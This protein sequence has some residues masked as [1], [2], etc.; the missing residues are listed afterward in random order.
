MN[1]LRFRYEPD[2]N[3]CGRLIVK[4][5]ANDYAGRGQSWFSPDDLRDFAK[6]TMSY[7]LSVES[8]PSLGAG[9]YDEQG[10]LKEIHVGILLEPHD[11]RG[12]VRATVRLATEVWR[13]EEQELFSSTVIRFL[14]TYAD[15]S[16]FG[17]AFIDLI[18]GKADEVALLS[19]A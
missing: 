7:P 11:K 12:L 1:L 17:P 2:D 4:C 8:L 15:L 6:A 16:T 14:L 10:G 3:S 13:S 18:D 19:S 5:E 9:F